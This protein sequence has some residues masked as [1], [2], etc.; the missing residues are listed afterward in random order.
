MPSQGRSS[1]TPESTPRSDASFSSEVE[2]L[3]SNADQC[4]QLEGCDGD[5]PPLDEVFWDGFA[6]EY[7]AL[8]ADISQVTSRS[9]ELQSQIAS[10]DHAAILDH[11]V[12]GAFALEEALARAVSAAQAGSAFGEGE[13]VDVDDVAVESA[14]DLWD[15]M[16]VAL[17]VLREHNGLYTAVLAQNLAGILEEFSTLAAVVLESGLERSL[18]E[19]AVQT[20]EEL[21]R[22]Q[23][24]WKVA[25]TSVAKIPADI[26]VDAAVG[27]TITATVPIVLGAAGVTGTL[28]A[29]AVALLIAGGASVAWNAVTDSW[30]TDVSSLEDGVTQANGMFDIGADSAAIDHVGDGFKATAESAGKISTGI[31]VLMDLAATGHAIDGIYEAA[32]AWESFKS[33]HAKLET[34]WQEAAVIFGGFVRFSEEMK[35]ATLLLGDEVR[36]R[37]QAIDEVESIYGDGLYDV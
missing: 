12:D 11:H 35:V 14:H 16:E 19:A 4:A 29:V 2:D 5:V 10:A 30:G 3:G 32:A 21:A 25:G 31:T 9:I 37:R 33:E 27:A 36:R 1:P 23:D 17:D 18:E 22:F 34:L 13:T 8:Q 20:Q 7:A 15:R 6:D 26:L 24:A 28:P